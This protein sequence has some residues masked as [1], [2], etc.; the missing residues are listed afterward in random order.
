M[1]FAGVSTNPDGGAAEPA[2]TQAASRMRRNW[3]A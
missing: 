3:R 2:S 1:G